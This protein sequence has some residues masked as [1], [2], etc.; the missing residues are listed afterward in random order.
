VYRLPRFDFGKRGV[1]IYPNSI[2]EGADI[3]EEVPPHEDIF[4]YGLSNENTIKRIDKGT[5]L[6]GVS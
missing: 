4:K 6:I 2:V 1:F 3:F 5:K